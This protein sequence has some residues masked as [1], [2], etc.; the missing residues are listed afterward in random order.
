MA[1]MR[2]ATGEA[3][4]TRREIGSEGNRITGDAG[5]SGIGDR[6]TERSEVAEKPE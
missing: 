5:K 2:R 4:L 6:V 1:R 3:L